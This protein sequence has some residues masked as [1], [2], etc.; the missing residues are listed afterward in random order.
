[1]SKPKRESPFSKNTKEREKPESAGKTILQ[2]LSFLVVLG[3]LGLI[4]GH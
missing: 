4:F 2:I 1:M 3:V